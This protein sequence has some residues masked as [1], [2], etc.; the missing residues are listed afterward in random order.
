MAITNIME[1]TTRIHAT[2]K[3]NAHIRPLP[4]SSQ[5]LEAAALIMVII[6]GHDKC[7]LIL[8]A[9]SMTTGGFD[10]D[11]TQDHDQ[12]RASIA[13]GVKVSHHGAAGVKDFDKHEVDVDA[14][15]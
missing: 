6:D 5:Q 14:F 1:L 10:N 8:G 7:L 13:N 12:G 11:D 4:V 15:H 2:G 3:A 9:V